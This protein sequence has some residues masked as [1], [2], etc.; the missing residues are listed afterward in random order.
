MHAEI[1]EH[2]QHAFQ[3]PTIHQFAITLL[4][5]AAQQQDPHSLTHVCVA[6][7]D[8]A[9]NVQSA[10]IDWVLALLH[11]VGSVLPP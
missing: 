7:N 9:E 5:N 10:I 6:H 2:T 3:K 8:I 11:D 1:H 4:F